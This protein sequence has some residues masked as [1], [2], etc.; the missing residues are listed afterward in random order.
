MT[1]PARFKQPEKT[2]IYDAKCFK[3]F[4]IWGWKQLA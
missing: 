4:Q 2:E 3:V 1:T